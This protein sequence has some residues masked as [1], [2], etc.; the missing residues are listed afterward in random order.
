MSFSVWEQ[1]GQLKLLTMRLGVLHEAQIKQLKIWPRVFFQN[2]NKSQF[3]VD[4]EKK[5]IVFDVWQNSSKEN[6]LEKKAPEILDQNT[7]ELLGDDW[8]V[9]IVLHYPKKKDVIHRFYRK[10][11]EIVPPSKRKA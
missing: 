6:A 9:R 3:S 10:V 4:I 7:K 8:S 1:L 2:S 11:P 5:S